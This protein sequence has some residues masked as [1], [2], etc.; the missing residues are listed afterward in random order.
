[1]R[2]VHVIDF[3][4]S[5]VTDTDFSE[6]SQDLKPERKFIKNGVI[7]RQNIWIEVIY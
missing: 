1:M 4:V 2:K 3:A 5:H 6:Y 7:H